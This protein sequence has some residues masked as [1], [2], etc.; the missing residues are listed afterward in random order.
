MRLTISM[1]HL[2]EFGERV[3]KLVAEVGA[4][5]E[6]VAQ[7]REEVVNG[8][9]DEW[10][11]IAVLH[12]SRVDRDADQQAGGIGH[13]MSLAA[14]DLL[15]RIVAARPAA[16][17][18]L[19]RLAIDHAGRGARFP[20]GCFAHLQQQFKIDLLEQTI[21]APIIKVTLPRG[22]WGKVFGN[23]RH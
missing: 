22:E 18:R 12:I 5:G 20:T 15:G 14:F 4:I 23:M 2:A 7:A 6:D 10:R 8:L 1:L 19:H 16:L 3:Q 13:D 21:I 17:G 9:D 11:A